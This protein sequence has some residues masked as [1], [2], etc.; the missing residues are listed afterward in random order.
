MASKASNGFKPRRSETPLDEGVER[1][2]L[3]TSQLSRTLYFD[4]RLL[5]ANDLVRDQSWLD[6]RLREVGRALG[7]GV[8]RGL[9]ASLDGAVVSV[10]AGVAVTPAGRVIELDEPLVVDLGDRALMRSVNGGRS[11]FLETGVYAV[12][13]RYAETEEGLAEVFPAELGRKRETQ[14]D[15]IQEGAEL[16]LVRLPE[17]LPDRR[18]DVGARAELGARILQRAARYSALPQDGVVV[19][20]LGV[21]GDAPRWLDPELL[22]HPLRFAGEPAAFAQDLARH[23]ASLF[24]LLLATRPASGPASGFA[25]SSFVELLPAAGPAPKGAFDPVAGVQRFFPASFDVAIAPVRS[26]ELPV[27]IAESR[28]LEPL[29]VARGLPASVLALVRLP[30]ETF[31]P[32]A[33]A[34]ERR[35]GRPDEAELSRRQFDRIEPLRLRFAKAPV[36][37]LDTDADAW[38]AIW[39]AA[40]EGDVFYVRR[41]ARATTVGV[42]GLVLARGAPAPAP[43]APP[44]APDGGGGLVPPLP[45]D[46]G[47]SLGDLRRLGDVLGTLRLDPRLAP[48]PV[49]APAPPPEPPPSTTPGVGR[50]VDPRARGDLRRWLDLRNPPTPEAERS[51]TALTDRFGDDPQ[52]ADQLA[53]IFVLVDRKFDAA[54]WPTL[55]E[56]ARNGR[57]DEF[58]QR[59]VKLGR[60][61]NE[62]DVAGIART[63]RLSTRTQSLWS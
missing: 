1:V 36:H 39:R 62:R 28:D 33:R 46:L 54:L 25:A 26:D 47:L 63:M 43:V 7:D 2:G 21:R 59:L 27:L 52:V 34:L 58:Q 24:P 22:R 13:L 4:G 53:E 44:E 49:P 6:E 35:D 29:E 17:A 50:G 18:D 9:D 61:P 55:E 32:L 14:A 51:A 57:L 15:R 38:T 10:D 56:L 31:E 12:V 3:V 60:A 42:S 5:T 19:G 45:P 23:W 41:P 20:V 16:V 40:G 11:V 8:V 48:A 37:A 30:P